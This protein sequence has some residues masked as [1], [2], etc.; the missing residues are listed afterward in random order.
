MIL[1]GLFVIC[2]LKMNWKIFERLCEDV[3]RFGIH[4]IP[5]VAFVANLSVEMKIMT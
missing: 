4:R 2:N 3:G 5:E 1:V